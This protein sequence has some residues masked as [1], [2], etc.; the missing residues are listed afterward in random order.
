MTLAAGAEAPTR[1][2]ATMVLRRIALADPGAGFADA[3]AGRAV[4]A[5]ETASD[6]P[7]R[8]WRD[9]ADRG[10]GRAPARSP[11]A[12]EDPSEACAADEDPSEACAADDSPRSAAAVA[13]VEASQAPTPR[14]TANAPTRPTA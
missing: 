7:V 8:T 4:A 10:P 6:W 14:A 11:A 1:A 5:A 9:A 12:D 2:G 13:G 3:G